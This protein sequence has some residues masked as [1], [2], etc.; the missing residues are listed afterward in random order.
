MAFYSVAIHPTRPHEIA[1]SGESSYVAVCDARIG[2]FCQLLADPE[3]RSETMTISGVAYDSI[4]SALLA[5]YHGGDIVEFETPSMSTNR[6]DEVARRYRGHRNAQ[7]IKHV[8]YGPEDLHVVSGSDDGHAFFFNRVSTD[9]ECIVPGDET[10]CNAIAIDP[11]TWSVCTAGLDSSIK[12]LDATAEKPFDVEDAREIIDA[13][14]ASTRRTISLSRAQ[15][16]SML[17]MLNSGQLSEEDQADLVRMLETGELA[18]DDMV[19]STSDDG[20]YSSTMVDDENDQ[21]E[22]GASATSRSA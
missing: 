4:G 18:L 7:T 11:S 22:D 17:T 13:N 3:R 19:D 12:V 8:M 20:S 21:D 1:V 15:V 16:M 6:V 5:S 14:L 2:D 9:I 10:I